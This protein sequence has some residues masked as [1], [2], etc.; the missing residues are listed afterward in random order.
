MGLLIMTTKKLLLIHHGAASLGK[1]GPGA[2]GT[3]TPE[4]LNCLLLEVL[5]SVNHRVL[6]GG[7]GLTASHWLGGP[8]W[9][10]LHVCCP[11]VVSELCHP[12]ITGARKRI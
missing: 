5:S 6:S 3:G 10:P 7:L 9:C 4:H 1:S 11:W 2:L 8:R 12:P